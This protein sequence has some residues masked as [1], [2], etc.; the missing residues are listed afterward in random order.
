[1]FR[2]VADKG[3]GKPVNGVMTQNPRN[4]MN[5]KKVI[6]VQPSPSPEN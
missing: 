4:E 5:G 6:E 1:M 3:K 2:E